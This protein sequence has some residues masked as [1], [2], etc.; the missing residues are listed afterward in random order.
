MLQMCG[1]IA[2]QHQQVIAPD[3]FR[4]L[5]GRLLLGLCGFGVFGQRQ[6]VH[7]A[8]QPL[9]FGLLLFGGALSVVSLPSLAL[10]VVGAGEGV[11]LG[12]E[13]VLLGGRWL[14]CL[15]VLLGLLLLRLGAFRGLGALLRGPFRSLKLPYELVLGLCL[16]IPKR[17][18]VLALGVD[19]LDL[20]GLFGGGL[21]HFLAI[22]APEF[23]SGFP[24]G[25]LPGEQLVVTMLIGR[26]AEY[27]EIKLIQGL[28]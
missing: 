15:E 20:S 26:H 5:V 8:L 27:S 23:G 18:V 25:S 6:H 7:L 21:G 28:M 19:L 3:A 12:L 1:C 10:T 13:G 2:E 14:L 4:F 22:K 16:D 24:W 9:S 17:L 11:A